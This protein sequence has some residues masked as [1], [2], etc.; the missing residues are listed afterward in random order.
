MKKRAEYCSPWYRAAYGYANLASFPGT[1]SV[2]TTATTTF[3][4]TIAAHPTSRSYD[5]QNAL[6]PAAASSSAQTTTPSP[7]E[8]SVPAQHDA[9]TPEN[10]Q[11]CQSSNP[12]VKNAKE[13]QSRKILR[14]H[15]LTTLPVSASTAL[16][17]AHD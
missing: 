4:P 1:L 2:P 3:S 13:D 7:A 10:T 6:P 5:T 17:E 12:L 11:T 8:S 14:P 16:L 9:R 15:E